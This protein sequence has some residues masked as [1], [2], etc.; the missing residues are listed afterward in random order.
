MSTPVGAVEQYRLVCLL[1]LLNFVKVQC[2]LEGVT[3]LFLCLPQ[4]LSTWPPQV[5][6]SWCM[7][8]WPTDDAMQTNKLFSCLLWPMHSPHWRLKRLPC[9]NNSSLVNCYT[10]MLDTHGVTTTCQLRSQG[11]L[12]FCGTSSVTHLGQG[13]RKFPAS[14]VPAGAETALLHAGAVA[15]AGAYLAISLSTTLHKHGRQ[16]QLQ[17]RQCSAVQKA[18]GSQAS[19]NTLALCCTPKV[20]HAHVCSCVLLC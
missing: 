18:D 4:Q 17:I 12:A 19:S 1:C 7:L 6:H 8:W 20:P 2:T 16:K 11:L 10:A 9:I 15:A 5:Q 3:T 14:Q 13:G